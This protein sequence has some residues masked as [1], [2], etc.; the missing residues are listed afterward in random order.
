[1]QGL[2]VSVLEAGNRWEYLDVVDL[3]EGRTP[4]PEDRCGWAIIHQDG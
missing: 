2:G 4:E 1:M 3:K